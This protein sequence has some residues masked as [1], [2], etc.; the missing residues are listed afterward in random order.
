VLARGVQKCLH[1]LETLYCDTDAGSACSSQHRVP[2]YE[3]LPHSVMLC[4]RSSCATSASAYLL[5]VIN[6]HVHVAP[7]VYLNNTGEHLQRDRLPSNQC[8]R[9]IQCLHICLRYVH[10]NKNA[11]MHVLVRLL[12]DYKIACKQLLLA[13]LIA[14]NIVH[15]TVHWQLQRQHGRDTITCT[16]SCTRCC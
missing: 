9:W 4:Q 1:T 2:L 12:T 7:C 10:Y 16:N 3:S 11:D 13:L 5:T 8:A 14:I 6:V 15:V